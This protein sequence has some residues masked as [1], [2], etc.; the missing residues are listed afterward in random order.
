MGLA[1]LI[2]KYLQL[3]GG[4]GAIDRIHMLKKIVKE[5]DNIVAALHNIDASW[6]VSGIFPVGRGGTGLNTI[7]LGG[8]LYASALDVLSRLA[9]TA[10][11]QVLRS[12][13]ANALQFAALL[14]ADIPN[15]DAAKITSGQFPL[16]RMP[17]AA[18]GLFLEGNGVGANPIFNALVAGDIPNLDAAKITSGIFPVARG[19]TGLSTIALGGILYA[20]AL[21]VLSRLA[22]TAANQVLRSTAANALQFAALLAADIPNLPAAKITSGRFPMTRMPDMALD[23]IMVGQGAG[24]S[25]VEEDKPSATPTTIGTYTGNDTV[26]RAIAHGLGVTPKIVLIYSTGG[27]NN[28]FLR[29]MGGLAMV[30]YVNPGT[31]SFLAVTAPDTTNFYVGNVTSY[32][33]SANDDPYAYYWVA[34]G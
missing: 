7:A 12:T 26:N 9:P 30:L 3:E 18:A 11:N 10:A 25:P 33:R 4:N 14:A 29:I 6:V 21:N 13:A 31:G 32:S 1:N 23:K 15:L 5:A 2:S 24:A 19:G 27:V 28:A 20:S 17:R 16:T 34:I 8:I 22:P